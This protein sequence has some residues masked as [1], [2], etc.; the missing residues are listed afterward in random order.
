MYKISG[1][2]NFFKCNNDEEVAVSLQ[3]FDGLNL[4]MLLDSVSKVQ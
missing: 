3:K 1:S 4:K 2:G